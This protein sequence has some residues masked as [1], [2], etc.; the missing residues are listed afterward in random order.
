[1]PRIINNV[2]T[3]LVDAVEITSPTDRAAFV[4]K[5]CGGD[6][7]LQ[8]HVEELIANHFQAGDF[9]Q[10]AVS[11]DAPTYITDES[12]APVGTMI[13]PYKLREVLGQGGMGVVYVAEQEQP[14][15]R[16]VALNILT[17][18]Q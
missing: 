7:V 9:L 11:I 18:T 10:H 17:L 12:A 1:M 2:D 13:G 5:A 6:S 4:A 8:R 3:I 15:R 14:L 16:K